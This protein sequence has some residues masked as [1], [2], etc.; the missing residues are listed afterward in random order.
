VPRR[1]NLGYVLVGFEG[2]TDTDGGL[3][4]LRTIALEERWVTYK[5]E[6]WCAKKCRKLNE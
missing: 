1:G 4:T 2:T 5:G 3:S 6:S